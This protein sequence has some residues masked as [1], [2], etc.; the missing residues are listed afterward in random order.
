MA[1]PPSRR[2]VQANAKHSSGLRD[3]FASLRRLRRDCVSAAWLIASMFPWCAMPALRPHRPPKEH[4]GQQPSASGAVKVREATAEGGLTFTAST[5][6][7]A[8]RWRV[9]GGS[10][11]R[12]LHPAARPRGAF[13]GLRAADIGG[14]LP[15]TVKLCANE[16]KT[17]LPTK[18][19]WP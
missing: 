8:L 17:S 3:S 12:S 4:G 14:G 16:G 18:P 11:Q 1:T 9:S 19:I 6:M 5:A 2:Q 10:P 15:P 7:A 13:P